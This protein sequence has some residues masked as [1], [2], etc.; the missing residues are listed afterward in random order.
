L[1]LHYDDY[2]KTREVAR[3]WIRLQNVELHNLYASTSVIRVIKVM[4]MRCAVHVA[5]VGDMRTKYIILVRNLKGRDHFGR[6]RHRWEDNIIM[7]LRK[8]G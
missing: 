6:P 4:R 8:I 3:G 1:L 7:D 5:R 2:P